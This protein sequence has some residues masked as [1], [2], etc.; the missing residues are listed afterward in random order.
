LKT[1]SMADL[2][3]RHR[4]AAKDVEARVL[5]VLRTG[6]YVGGPQVRAAEATAARWFGRSDAVGVNSGTDALVLA[7]QAVGVRPEDE[8][9]VPALS[10]FA[11]AGA[12]RALGA[13]PV[14]VDVLE[15]GCMD[16]DAARQALTRRTRAAVPVHLFGTVARLPSVPVPVVDDAAQAVGGDPPRSMGVLTGLSTYPTKTWGG[17]GDGGFVVGD[18][19]ALLALVRRQ[20]NHG[21]VDGQYC[22]LDGMAGGNSRLDALQAAVLLGQEPWI[23]PRVAHRRALA[24]RYDAGLPQAVRPLPRDPGSPVQ[25]YLVLVEERD[26]VRAA[27]AGSGIETRVYYPRPLHREP[28]IA[29]QAH[30]P[31]A[32]HLCDRLLALPV[33]SALTEADVD[34]VLACLHQAVG[35]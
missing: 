16:P 12:V 26:R 7:L 13:V 5:E 4:Q 24:A 19:P 32:D 35:G 14:V 34:H 15:D 30:T 8:V 28:A 29:S 10:F 2:A 23:A 25:Q 1:I 31:V 18:D 17:A 6:T 9:I 11:T 3:A 27:L 33:H 20:A 21:L 22:D